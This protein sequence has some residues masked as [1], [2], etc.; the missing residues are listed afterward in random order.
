MGTVAAG[1]ESWTLMTLTLVHES[2]L[3]TIGIT[4]IGNMIVP[5]YLPDLPSPSHLAGKS[6]PQIRPSSAAYP[7]DPFAAQLVPPLTPT[8]PLLSPL[9]D[10]TPP[11]AVIPQAGRGLPDD[12]CTDATGSRI[13]S[14]KAHPADLQWQVSVDILLSHPFP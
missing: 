8:R 3:S 14:D 12:G 6:I 4:T 13:G 7:S 11:Q 10:R 5:D 9:S 1:R 2:L